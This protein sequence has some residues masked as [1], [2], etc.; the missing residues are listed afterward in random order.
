MGTIF[1]ITAYGDHSA[2]LKEVVDRAFREIDRL[3]SEMSHYKPESELSA[4]NREAFR[5]RVVVTPGLFKL[6]EDC[7]RY[8]KET[9][10]I[11]D[12]TIGPLM[13]AWGFF[14]GWGRF[15]SQT[16]L[17]EVMKRVGY[18]HVTLD[19][20]TRTIEFDA[21]GVDLDFGAIGKGYAVDRVVKILRSEGVLQALVSS[22]ASSIYALG[23]PPGKE[24]WEISVCHPFDRRKTVC[25]LRLQNLSIS[26]SGD[27]EKF[28]ESNGKIYSHIMDPRNGMP[29]E[30]RLMTVVI[31]S[32]AT[33]GDALSTSFLVGGITQSREYLKHHSNLTAIFYIPVRSTREVEELV[34]KSSEI[35]VA[36]DRLAR[37]CLFR[38][39]NESAQHKQRAQS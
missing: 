4:I 37:M 6:L 36:V 14:Q 32:S 1:S 9:G 29:T 24:G 35:K 23:A 7:L 30:D 18:R 19:A 13:K 22:G 12:I 31:S 8:S 28:F 25:R 11:F 15:P 26:V 27:L 34:L 10:G 3:N 33:Q 17:T 20:A 2:Q 5:H 16:E 39:S 21:P 38:E